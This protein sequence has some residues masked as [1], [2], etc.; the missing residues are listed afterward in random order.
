MY[1]SE[2]LMCC[3]DL[4]L[5]IKKVFKNGKELMI[6]LF[7]YRFLDTIPPYAATGKTFFWFY[8]HVLLQLAE[9]LLTNVATCASQIY[10]GQTLENGA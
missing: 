8:L 10:F 2:K 3:A 7:V 5:L 9:E 1:V 6:L 4:S